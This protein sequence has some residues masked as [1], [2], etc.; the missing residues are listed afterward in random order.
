MGLELSEW[1]KAHASAYSLPLSAKNVHVRFVEPAA[2]RPGWRSRGGELTRTKS[3][4]VF[5]AQHTHFMGV[6]LGTVGA[7]FAREAS[8]IALGFGEADL[9]KAPFRVE[10]S[11]SGNAPTARFVL[12]PTPAERL[13]KPLGL[14]LLGSGV[15]VSSETTIAFASGAAEGTVSGVSNVTLQGYTPPHPFE[16]DG[17]IFGDTTR[18]DTKFTLPKTR[19]RITLTNSRL[20]AGRFVLQGDGLLSRGSDHSEATLNLSGEL[21]CSAL[22]GVE[23]ESRLGKLLGATLAGQGG[24]AG[25]ENRERQRPRGTQVERGHPST[26]RRARGAHDRRG[27]RPAPALARRAEQAVA[28]GRQR[29]AQELADLTHRSRERA[30]VVGLAFQLASVPERHAGVTNGTT[31]APE[32]T[33]PRPTHEPPDPARSDSQSNRHGAGELDQQAYPAACREQQLMARIAIL[34][35]GMMGSALALPLIDRGHELRLIGTE[36]DAEIITALKGGQEHPTLRLPLPR[37]ITAFHA[38]EL[39]QALSGVDAIALGVSSAGVRWAGQALAPL[40]SAGIPLLMI[41]KGLVYDGQRFEILPDVLR[42]ELPATLAVEP[43]AV[44]GPCIAGELARRVETCVVFTGRN[45]ESV[46][47]WAELARGR[48]YHVFTSSDPV[49]TEVCAALKNAYA[50]GIGFAAGLHEKSG[51]SAGSIAMHNCEAALYAQAIL[52]AKW[53]V[54]LLGGDPECVSGLPSR[55]I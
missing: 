21:P 48:Y 1:T 54:G 33:E 43:V 45:A 23:A 27:L 51:G 5:A 26:Q 32:A 37:T 13:A 14:G 55:E 30:S 53:L 2:R 41:S 31:A 20:E 49:G 50:M 11:P 46:N 25:R 22:A 38:A 16:L 10:I 29:I 15:V 39:S 17:F 6:D 44:G 3:G 36:L 28:R 18:F 40:L 7:G 34:G 19:D 47:A 35:A 24:Q 12:A 8:S 52:E 42:R 9:S 4:G